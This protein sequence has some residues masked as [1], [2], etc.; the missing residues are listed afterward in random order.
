MLRRLL[1]LVKLRKEV[2]AATQTIYIN[3]EVNNEL[4]KINEN[5]FLIL[6]IFTCSLLLH[7]YLLRIAL[8]KE[9]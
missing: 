1:L 7:Q 5:N 8:L 4:E 6:L 9:T 3:I 2:T